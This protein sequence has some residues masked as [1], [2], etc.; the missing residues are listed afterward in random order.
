MI[1]LCT[2]QKNAYNPES[3]NRETV[4]KGVREYKREVR[5]PK[6]GVGRPKKKNQEVVE[7][8]L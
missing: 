3:P 8:S 6:K 4:S 1:A 7:S 5:V 2:P